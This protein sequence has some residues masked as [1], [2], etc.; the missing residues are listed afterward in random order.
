V[1]FYFRISFC[2]ASAKLLGL[3]W[4]NANAQDADLDAAPSNYGLNKGALSICQN[5]TLR[6]QIAKYNTRYLADL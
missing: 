3:K 6:S 1:L 5:L 2:S 4:L